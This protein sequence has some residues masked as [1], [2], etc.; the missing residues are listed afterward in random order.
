MNFMFF[1]PAR[2]LCFSPDR[3]HSVLEGMDLIALW[4]LVGGTEPGCLIS[5]P[6]RDW[7][8]ASWSWNCLIVQASGDPLSFSSSS[9]LSLSLFFISMPLPR[10]AGFAK[11]RCGPRRIC[12]EPMV[13]PGALPAG[14]RCEDER[15]HRRVLLSSHSSRLCDLSCW[16][17]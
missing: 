6:C 11:R 17:T 15:R 14:S 5:V 12:Q 2:S 16:N 1:L 13:F 7:F 4:G 3:F 8:N 9:S 10:A